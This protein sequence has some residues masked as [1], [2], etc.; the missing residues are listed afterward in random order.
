[1]N[2]SGLE[3]ITSHR[4]PVRRYGDVLPRRHG[5][6]GAAFALA[7]AR[8]D[9]ESHQPRRLRGRSRLKIDVRSRSEAC[10]DGASLWRIAALASPRPV[11]RSAE[12]LDMVLD[13]PWFRLR[14]SGRTL[15]AGTTT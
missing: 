7:T 13:S 2:P 14:S 4:G 11:N 6:I 10:G 9:R 8:P 15:R 3:Q 1:M 5:S 12:Q